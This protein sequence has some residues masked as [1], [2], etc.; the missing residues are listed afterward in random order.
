MK[1]AFFSPCLLLLLVTGSFGDRAA[2]QSMNAGNPDEIA[3]P[4]DAG[5]VDVTK[6][7][8]NAKGDGIA[9]DT[10]AIQKDAKPIPARTRSSICRAE[11]IWFPISCAGHPTW[12]TTA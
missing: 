10:A 7:P 12:S 3:F 4:A 8:Y 11:P 6:P 5:I 9:D 2:I 1:R